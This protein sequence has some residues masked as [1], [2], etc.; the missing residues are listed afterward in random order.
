[1]DKKPRMF[2]QTDRFKTKLLEVSEDPMMI[3]SPDNSI[4]QVN[5]LL[6]KLTGFSSLDLIGAMAPY[7]WWVKENEKDYLQRLED[8]MQN[9]GERVEHVFRRK[10]GELFWVEVTSTPAVRDGRLVYLLS[11][12]VDITDRN[13]V[14]EEKM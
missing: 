6:E 12:W 1:M 11:R 13:R 14:K 10:T 2:K 9:G 7:P 3:I 5:S 8:A 4:M